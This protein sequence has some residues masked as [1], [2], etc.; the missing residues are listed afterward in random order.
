MYVCAPYV[1][2][3]PS[4]VRVSTGSPG[5]GVASHHVGAKNQTNI[6]CKRCKCSPLPSSL[7]SPLFNCVYVC[8][9]LCACVYEYPWKLRDSV[10]SPGAVAIGDCDL[11][12]VGA[13]RQTV[14]EQSVLVTAGRSLQPLL[15]DSYM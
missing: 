4:E 15:V 10:R 13:G 5:T 6:L 14:Q 7:T 8:V 9:S 3:V 11:S 1:C 12:G 2:L